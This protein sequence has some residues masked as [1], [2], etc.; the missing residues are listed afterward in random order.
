MKQ[1]KGGGGVPDR[2][3]KSKERGA[4]TGVRNCQGVEAPCP[5]D[6][7]RKWTPIQESKYQNILGRDGEQGGINKYTRKMEGTRQVNPQ[8]LSRTWV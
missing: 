2:V 4:G 6:L 1:E 7:T 8:R 5:L 3:D